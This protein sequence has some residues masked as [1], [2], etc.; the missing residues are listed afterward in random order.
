MLKVLSYRRLQRLTLIVLFP[1]L[2]A[3]CAKSSIYDLRMQYLDHPEQAPT[4]CPDARVEYLDGMA[5]TSLKYGW[6]GAPEQTR[7]MFVQSKL[8]KELPEDFHGCAYFRLEGRVSTSGEN[9]DTVLRALAEDK[10][11]WQ[12][13]MLVLENRVPDLYPEARPI[14]DGVLA[15][16]RKRVEDGAGLTNVDIE[17]IKFPGAQRAWRIHAESEGVNQGTRLAVRML[18][19]VVAGDVIFTYSATGNAAQAQEIT[20]GQRDELSFLIKQ[21]PPKNPSWAELDRI[22]SG[23]SKHLRVNANHSQFRIGDPLI[24]SVNADRDGYLNVLNVSSGE[25]VPTVLYPNRLHPENRVS[26]GQLIEIPA[27]EDGFRLTAQGP[28]GPSLIVVF[29]SRRP[30]NAYRDGNGNPED[31]FRSLSSTKAFAVVARKERDLAAGRL[32]LTVE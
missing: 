29:L 16:I 11:Q 10:R 26:P 14:T 18:M 27:P 32:V 19:A 30:I 28:S 20:R 17:E 8:S 21:L 25:T 2:A 1:V 22:V 3:G 4:P 13:F 9:P 23:A 31:L 6:N 24:I 15:G 7:H 12:R 5:E